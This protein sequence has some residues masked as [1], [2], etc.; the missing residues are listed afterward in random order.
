MVKKIAAVKA[1]TGVMTQRK[2]ARM[3]NVSMTTI[4]NVLHQPELVNPETLKAIRRIMDECDYYPDALA[5]AMVRGKSNIV[6]VMVPRFDIPYFA[7]MVCRIE[8]CI[9][10]RNYK[11]LMI[12]HDDDPGKAKEAIRVF[13]QYRADGIILRGCSLSSDGE[14]AKLAERYRIPFV[15]LDEVIQGYEKF[16]I[17]PADYDDG[18][19]AA[20]K[21]IA[22]GCRRI[23]YIGWYRADNDALGPRFEGVAAALREHGIPFPA[24]RF[25]RTASEY[26]AGREEIRRLWE[27][28]EFAPLD[29]VICSNTS[30][31][32]NVYC[33]LRELGVK[34]PKE[35]KL[36]GFGDLQDQGMLEPQAILTV[37][38]DI[39]RIAGYACDILVDFMEFGKLPQ[40]AV[41]VPSVM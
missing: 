37:R 33:G 12:Q 24:E 3:A 20:E 38:H 30:I 5:Q 29:G 10:K 17:L 13:R 15:L 36:L 2:L 32:V 31:V 40:Q 16:T 4:Y 19:N 8:R 11:C 21:L 1:G 9:S 14:L 18:K 35:I 26:N 25:G 41:M 7:N 22:M 39:D 23:G 27:R 6:G 28:N 34:V